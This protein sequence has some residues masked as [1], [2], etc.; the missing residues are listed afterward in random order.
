MPVVPEGVGIPADIDVHAE[1]LLEISLAIENL[2]HQRFA[3]R[4]VEVGLDPHTADD[5]PAALFHPLLDL[6]KHAGILFFDPLVSLRRAGGELEI[7]VFAHQFQRRAEGVLHDLDG[8]SPWPKPRHIDVAV[9]DRLHAELL[10]VRP[11]RF[12]LGLCRA[13][14]AV[15]RRLDAFGQRRKIDCLHGCV[16]LLLTFGLTIGICG[17][18]R[19]SR[20]NF[21]P[22]NRRIGA[23]RRR[24]DQQLRTKE[25]RRQLAATATYPT[26][27]Q[28]SYADLEGLAGLGFFGQ[29][30]RNLT[31]RI[32]SGHHI[33]VDKN[34][35]GDCLVAFD[36]HIKLH[37]R[38]L[39]VVAVQ[40]LR[41]S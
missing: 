33:A 20:Q 8:L 25:L 2:S 39:Q 40:P 32:G 31:A 17:D 16:E 19:L 34:G 11:Q 30:N 13:Q 1:L 10:H 22:K 36:A 7:G 21:Q 23:A 18:E 4:H 14:R 15:E 29:G 38:I 26:G 28:D 3:V 24:L 27:F 35:N 37:A 5:L 6:R 41:K 12:Q 9:A